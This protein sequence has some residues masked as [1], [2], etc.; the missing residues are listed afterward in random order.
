MKS[1]KIEDTSKKIKTEKL[2]D[3]SKRSALKE[4]R[5]K[6]KIKTTQDDKY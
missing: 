1:E 3:I 4:T 6:I 5:Q 2:K